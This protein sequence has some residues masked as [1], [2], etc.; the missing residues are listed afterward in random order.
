MTEKSCFYLAFP[1]ILS[2]HLRVLIGRS[3]FKVI[4]VDTDDKFDKEDEWAPH[5]ANPHFALAIHLP[6][7]RKWSFE[8]WAVQNMGTIIR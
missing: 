3:I 1:T 4:K 5:P 6:V 8:F 2:K 7:W